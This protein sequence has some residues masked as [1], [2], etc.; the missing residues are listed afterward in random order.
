LTN[1][2]TCGSGRGKEKLSREAT[3]NRRCDQKGVYKFDNL[4]IGS[5]EILHPNHG[6]GERGRKMERGRAN[7]S[8]EVVE[9]EVTRDASG[10]Y[11]KTARQE[12]KQGRVPGIMVTKVV[13]TPENRDKAKNKTKSRR[14]N[15]L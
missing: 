6:S 7:K 10:R 1:V 2:I 4:D 8:R 5:A 12:G 13:L 3:L 14:G 11:S 15:M 9:T